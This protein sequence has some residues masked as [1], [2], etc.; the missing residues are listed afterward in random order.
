MRA[1]HEPTW[2][3][4]NI[5]ILRIG[6]IR[7]KTTSAIG[8]EIGVSKSSVISKA[9][10]IPGLDARPSPIRRSKEKVEV[11]K[12]A[13]GAA[14]RVSLPLPPIPTI[15]N[16]DRITQ[17][18]TARKAVAPPPPRPVQE[19]WKGRIK[20]CCWPIGEPGT[21]AFRFCDEPSEAGKPYCPEHC[22]AAFVGRKTPE[23]PQHAEAA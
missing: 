9:R 3:D 5:E 23:Q 11:M 8:R 15:T 19:V 2:T 16:L 13:R 1:D 12:G 22:N 21:K 14:L 6:W 4:E 18:T 10:R 7:G 17:Q 20:E